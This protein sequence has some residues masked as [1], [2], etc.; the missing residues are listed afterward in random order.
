MSEQAN[1]NVADLID[2]LTAEAYGGV[3]ALAEVRAQENTAQEAVA[4][5]ESVPDSEVQ[6]DGQDAPLGAEPPV[7]ETRLDEDMEIELSLPEPEDEAEDDD[8]I[9]EYA[10][11]R[12][13]AERERRRQL[14]REL[15][16]TRREQRR[17]EADRWKAEA[18]RVFPLL[19]EAVRDR[20]MA[21]AKSHRGFLRAAKE[22]HDLFV[23]VANRARK[24]VL[25]HLEQLKQQAVEEARVEAAEAWGRP[26]TGD[27]LPRRANDLSS[28]VQDRRGAQSLTDLVKAR[29]TAGRG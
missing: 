26:T 19:P 29:L 27:S 28:R 14:E 6:V 10:D 22:Q 24:D 3:D 7:Y 5:V 4:D 2:G 18:D 12:L 8:D 23:E 13:A 9:D 25:E 16:K 20:L 17:S 11:P 15:E 21:E 1:T